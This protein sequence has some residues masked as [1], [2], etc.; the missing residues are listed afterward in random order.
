MKQVLVILLE[1]DAK[2]EEIR[3]DHISDHEK[4][5]PH[6]T[7]VYPFEVEDQKKLFEHIQD[8]VNKIEPFELSLS[9]LEKSA[10]S[11]YLYLLIDKG[12]KNIMALHNQLNQGILAG[13]ENKSM[14]K[15]IPHLSLGLFENEEEIN[16]TMNNLKKEK[17][18][19]NTQVKSVQ[20]L[21]I[22]DEHN[23][24]SV[25]DFDLGIKK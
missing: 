13:F 11:F 14:P 22:D 20:L 17:L 3:K 8:C 21:N 6:I 2:I 16:K 12:Q 1:K 5:K 4:I 23:L 25:T 10:T 15:Y 24:I 19:F 9:G 18:I 7:L